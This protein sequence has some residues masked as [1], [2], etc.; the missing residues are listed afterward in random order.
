[1]KRQKTEKLNWSPKER[2]MFQEETEQDYIEKEQGGNASVRRVPT[3]SEK[4]RIQRKKKK[5]KRKHYILKLFLLL[6]IGIGLYAFAHSDAF[7]V[8]K[9]EMSESSRFQTEQIRE[10]CGLKTGINLFE[11]SARECEDKLLENPYIKEAKISR[12]L[13]DT[14]EVKLTERQE[15]ATLLKKSQYIVIDGEGIVLRSAKKLPRIPLLEGITVKDAQENRAVQVKEP[16]R[17]E[18]GMLFLKKMKDAD[19]YF[20]K[21]DVSGTMVKAFVMDKLFCKG[22]TENL[23]SGM[24]NGNLKA[25]IYD[26]YQKKTKKGII[27]VGDEQYYAFSKKTE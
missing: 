5:R 3:Q 2:A 9:I 15:T 13:P 4:K 1:M 26:L 19:L 11:F 17:L 22:K 20:K 16:E 6:V 7:L 23:V 10:L 27:Y 21:I 24:E 12:K 14:V 25:V 8:K 18:T